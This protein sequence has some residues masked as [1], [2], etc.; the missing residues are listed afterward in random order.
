ML[1]VTGLHCARILSRDRAGL[2][3]AVTEEVVGELLAW[4]N[5]ATQEAGDTEAEVE[6][7]SLKVLS[8][9]ILILSLFINQIIPYH[10]HIIF[11]YLVLGP[12]QPAA[13]EPGHPVPV[14]LQR[15][16]HQAAQQG[17]AQDRNMK[18]Q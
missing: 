17:Q 3:E 13:A 7:E 12:V 10:S 18:R 11:S 16:P 2:D 4:A 5:I 1:Q 15:A 8:L 9:A 6:A 14:R